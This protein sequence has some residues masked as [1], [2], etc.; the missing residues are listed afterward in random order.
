MVDENGQPKKFYH[1]VGR[2][3]KFDTFN[4]ELISATSG[5]HGHFGVGFYFTDT[6]RKAK[7][8]SDWYGGTGEVIAVYL[9]VENPFYVTEESLIEIGEKYKLNLPPK[10]AMAID[11]NDLLEKLKSI[12]TVAHELL[13]LINKHKDYEKGWKEFLANHKG[14]VPTSKL[15]LNTVA[16]WYEDTIAEKYTRGVS[17][18]TL[19]ELKE[20]GIEPKII[21]GY[22][23]DIRMDYLT[24]LG[25]SA[26]AW[27]DAI[28]KEGYDGIVA[29]DEFVVFEPNQIKSV[30]NKG[31]FSLESDNI[32][33][34][35]EDTLTPK[36]ILDY[37]ND[38]HE[39]G[40]DEKEY[41]DWEW[42]NKFDVYRLEDVKLSDL[43]ISAM[44][45]PVA[46]KYSLLDSDI[47]PIVVDSESK[48]ILDGNHRAKG[49]E[50]RG[51]E[52]IK[53]YVG[54]NRLIESLNDNFKRWF[55]NS[56]VVNEDGTPKVMYHGSPNLKNIVEFKPKGNKQWYFFSDSSDEAWRYSVHNTE[57]IGKFYIRAEKIFNPIK[58]S[59]EEKIKVEKFLE[60]NATYLINQYSQDTLNLLDE[61]WESYD[62]DLT[63]EQREELYNS[64]GGW[65]MR[66]IEKKDIIKHLFY[67]NLDNYIMLESDLMQK[68]IRENGYD[69]F[70]TLES[71]GNDFN[72]AVYSPNQIK[73]VN[74]R[75]TFSLKSNNIYESNRRY[76]NKAYHGTPNGGFHTFSYN[77]RGSGADTHG[78]GDYGKGFYFTPDKEHALSYAHG[79]T[80]KGKGNNPYLYTVELEMNNPFDMRLLNQHRDKMIPLM[81]EY[82]LMNIPDEEFEKLFKELGITEEE[83]EFMSKVA[84]SMNDNWG[85]WDIEEI[86]GERGYDS[87]IDYTG[88]EYVVFRPEQIKIID[89][90]PV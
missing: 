4:K 29:G 76:T 19:K 87:V 39:F 55:G 64:T 70:T 30:N 77:Y 89:K 32:Y 81:K 16:D 23:E 80:E 67:Y 78:V 84:D 48:F 31:S 13:S 61:D 65:V 54:Y 38:L 46:K 10:V 6:E 60:E 20:I 82:G 1:G 25:Q 57:N 44:H 40:Y 45:P 21:Y 35:N 79:L 53:A 26:T 56:K 2:A 71:G 69:S 73:S 18:Y 5:N 83:Y 24:D 37:I 72:I 66:M 11:I 62:K 42:I 27:T 68:Y 9:K 3:G 74:N 33:E 86:I 63:D 59:D 34:S 50:S 8:F 51:D 47:P 52:Y 17:E 22:D 36:E 90:Q 85:D 41:E 7:S 43:K 15:D 75:G 88:N 49:A 12:D 58:L 14:E 28:K